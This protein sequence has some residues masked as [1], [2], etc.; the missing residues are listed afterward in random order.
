[1]YM[2]SVC[3]KYPTQGGLSHTLLYLIAM[4]N[5]FY[6]LP[7]KKVLVNIKILTSL[8]NFVKNFCLNKVKKKECF[9]LMTQFFTNNIKVILTSI[10]V[11]RNDSRYQNIFQI[12][13]YY[14][15]YKKTH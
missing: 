9:S 11:M 3:K 7:V 12:T 10:L 6:H 2:L 13:K 4:F 14:K 1:M 5:H 15:E 8:S